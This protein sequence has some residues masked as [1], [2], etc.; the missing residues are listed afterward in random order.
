M[1]G[2]WL[3]QLSSLTL[4]IPCGNNLGLD[5]DQSLPRFI[6]R[7][8]KFLEHVGRTCFTDVRVEF[9]LDSCSIA[10]LGTC[11]A[12]KNAT[13]KACRALDDFLPD[14]PIGRISFDSPVHLRRAGRALFWSPAFELAFPK[15][16]AGGLSIVALDTERGE[17]E[18]LAVHDHDT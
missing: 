6:K 9:K 17:L 12:R 11:L 18:G 16:T 13:F 10:L 2:I 1:D 5:P 3:R 4:I 15:L 14:F 7:A 8:R